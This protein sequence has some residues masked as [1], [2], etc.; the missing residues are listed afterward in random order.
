MLLVEKK[1]I[2]YRIIF[3]G[4]GIYSDNLNR[5]IVAGIRMGKPLKII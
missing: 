2:E 3:V 5:P 4:S 1:K